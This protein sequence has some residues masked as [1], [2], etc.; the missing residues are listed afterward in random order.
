MT[1]KAARDCARFG[2]LETGD[3][4]IAAL[5]GGA[6]SVA[7]LHF[8][9]SIKEQYDLTLYAA[10]LH[11]GIR[12]D[13]AQRDENF[14]KILCEKYNIPLFCRHRDIPAL[15]RERG[16]SEE[17]CGRQERYAF[18]EE[19][20]ET[21]NAKI[22]LA[23]TASDNV[24]TLLFNLSRGSSLN[25]ACAIVQKRG[26]IIRPLLSCT[27]AEI[28]AYCDAHHLSFMTDSTNLSDDYTR[29]KIRHHAVPVLREL[30][31]DLEGAVLRFSRDMSEV[32][33]YL[34]RQAE[35]ALSDAQSDYGYRAESLLGCDIAV[36]K[37]AMILLI[38]KYNIM[39]THQRVDLL[40]EILQNGGAVELDKSHTF[41]CDRGLLRMRTA[42]GESFA[43][44]FDKPMRFSCDG[45]EYAVSAD[46]SLFENKSLTFRNN[47]P[48]DKAYY[49][50]GSDLVSV[51]M[52]SQYD[53]A[54][55]YY[56]TTFH[57]L[58]HSTMPESRCNRKA[59]QKLAAFGSEDYS[60]EELVAEIGSAMLCSS[61]KIDCDKAFNNS[62]A[63]IQ[64]WLR[65][66]KNDNKMIVW[67]SSRAEK[68]AKYILGV[69]ED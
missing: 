3:S 16:I 14:C 65:K 1:N 23:H 15:A 8:L 2:L 12:G 41:V 46:N 10:H 40:L 4:V 59:E 30:N 66:L 60:R 57:E 48:T 64:G 37:A 45:E 18:F 20:A 27:R 11:H 49:S 44:A 25:G 28:E 54:E 38:K 62:V 50:P 35:K 32:G 21:H 68:A 9:Y 43:L 34:T 53:I 36:L 26:N 5:S 47:V 19:L 31:P 33:A 56:S 61:V 63:Y 55:E 69:K 13:E 52:L 7:L 6:D 58:T 29:N 42:A 24:E 39:P 22:A 51:P 17:L 67:A